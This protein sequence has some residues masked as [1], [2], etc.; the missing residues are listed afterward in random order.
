GSASNTAT[1][2]DRIYRTSVPFFD[3]D[4]IVVKPFEEESA[5][6]STTELSAMLLDVVLKTHARASSRPKHESQ[7]AVPKFKKKISRITEVEKEQGTSP[8][9]L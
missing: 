8:L 3:H 2:S 6:G 1:S 9:S 7:G 4:S 5:V